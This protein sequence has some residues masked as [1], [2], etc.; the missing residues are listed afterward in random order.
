LTPLLF[1]NFLSD[2]YHSGRGYTTANHCRS[3]LATYQNANNTP[4][5]LIITNHKGVKQSLAAY[6]AH[7]T[8]GPK[9]FPIRAYALPLLATAIMDL[10]PNHP[11]HAKLI[12][13]AI[14]LSY[15]CM[16]RISELL[17][18]TWFDASWAATHLTLHLGATKG[19]PTGQTPNHSIQ[20]PQLIHMLTHL[21]QLIKPKST[22]PLIPFT[23]QY[24]NQVLKHA[25]T[26]INYPIPKSAFCTWHSFRHGRAIDLTKAGNPTSTL[27]QHGRW[28]TQAAA[29]LYLYFLTPSYWPANLPTEPPLIQW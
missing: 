9:R 22:E 15:L 4:F 13:L 19:D 24:L 23:A 29:Q 7:A 14:Y 16:L 11:L 5:H 20:A 21:H 25:L 8:A 1:I 3:A 10:F 2:L 12:I 6:Q 28:H 27:L 18:L 17:Q 26:L